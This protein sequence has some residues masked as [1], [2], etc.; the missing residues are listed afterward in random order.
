[1]ALFAQILAL[2]FWA[3][4]PI[5]GMQLVV[6]LLL[7]GLALSGTIRNFAES[8]S[9]PYAFTPYQFLWGTR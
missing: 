4:R 8:D 3:K 7:C 2:S 1:M 9:E 6:V 5:R